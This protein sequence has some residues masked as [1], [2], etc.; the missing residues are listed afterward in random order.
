MEAE[1]VKPNEMT[2]ATAMHVLSQVGES[3][4]GGI[5]YG[6]IWMDGGMCI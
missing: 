3:M 5:G 2:Y 4:T 6:C 1:G